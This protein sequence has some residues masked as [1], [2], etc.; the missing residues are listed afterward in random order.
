MKAVERIRARIAYSESSLAEPEHL[1]ADFQND[2]A[3][4]NNENPNP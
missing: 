3:R 1:I 2:I 4:W